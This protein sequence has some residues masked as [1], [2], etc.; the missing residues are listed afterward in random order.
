MMEKSLI[1][2][3]V[4]QRIAEETLG[5]ISQRFET[6]AIYQSSW[7]ASVFLTDLINIKS[8]VTEHNQRPHFLLWLLEHDVA[9][10]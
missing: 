8:Q 3:E 10:S 6:S 5:S 1:D 2:H 4:A 9:D 7:F